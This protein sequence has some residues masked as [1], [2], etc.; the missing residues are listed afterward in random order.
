[1]NKFVGY[2]SGKL[3]VTFEQASGQVRQFSQT[4]QGKIIFPFQSLKLDRMTG[5]LRLEPEIF[6]KAI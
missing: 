5:S 1:M 4:R 3:D 2:H 6:E